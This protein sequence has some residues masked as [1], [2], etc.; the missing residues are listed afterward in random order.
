M[1]IALNIFNRS[2]DAIINM[3]LSFLIL[4]TAACG[5][6]A[7][8]DVI[9]R[10]NPPSCLNLSNSPS[11]SPIL[12]SSQVT[13]SKHLQKLLKFYWKSQVAQEFTHQLDVC[14]SYPLE[15]K[16][17]DESASITM[18][19]EMH[20]QNR[21]ICQFYVEFPVGACAKQV[22]VYYCHSHIFWSLSI[23]L[24]AIRNCTNGEPLFSIKVPQQ[25]ECT[26]SLNIIFRQVPCNT[27]GPIKPRRDETPG[28]VQQNLQFLPMVA[29]PVHLLMKHFTT[30]GR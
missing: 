7:A 6:Q 10:C 28:H 12:P 8:V 3:H 11:I 13:E 21:A 22:Y 18:R 16:H 2:R 4:P 14:P 9:W 26:R 5:H 23:N 25:L 30:I 19:K 20:L 15:I 29:I 27:T 1:G 17:S 24:H